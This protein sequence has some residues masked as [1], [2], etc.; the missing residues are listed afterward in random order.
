MREKDKF[1]EKIECDS[2]DSSNLIS[3]CKVQWV[4]SHSEIQVKIIIVAL[5]AI[6][7]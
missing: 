3:K 7:Q 1:Y 5:L 2:V 4:E 6:V